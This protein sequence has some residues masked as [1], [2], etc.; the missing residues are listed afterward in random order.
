MSKALSCLFLWSVLPVLLW[1]QSA[2]CP[3]VEI[4]G[5]PQIT[6]PCSDSTECTTLTATYPDIRQTVDAP[7]AYLVN[8]I[9]YAGHEQ[10]QVPGATPILVNQDDVYSGVINLPFTFCFY[11][12]QYNQ[13]VVG[14]NGT[15]SFDVSYAGNASGYSMC[16]WW[17]TPYT[18]P[19]TQSP[20]PRNAIFACFHDIDPTVVGPADK[21]IEFALIGTAP[22]RRLVVN[23]RNIPQFSCISTSSTF[24]CVLYENTNVIEMYIQKKPVCS[25]WN[26]GVATIGVQNL[27]CNQAIAAPGRN[28]TV[29]TTT[30]ASSEAW[31]FIPNGPSLLNSVQLLDSSQAVIATGV[32][33]AAS[34]GVLTT[35]FNNIC[36]GGTSAQYYI[37]A[38]YT[39]CSGIALSNTDSVLLVRTLPPT[40]PAVVSP[41][42]YCQ[43]AAATALTAAGT[44]LLWYTAAAGG[45]GSAAAPTPSTTA[46]GNTT[47][48]VSQTANG[49]ESPRTPIVVEVNA[50]QHNTTTAQ[51][52]PGGTYPFGSQTITA[53]GTYAETFTAANGCDSVVTLTMTVGTTIQVNIDQA[54]CQGGNVTFNGTTY[55]ASGSYS[56]TTTSSGGCDSTTTL[57][58]TVSPQVTPAFAAIAPICSGAT[59]PVLP[60]TSTN[61]I[62]GT[63]S[64]ATVSNT[65]TGTYTFTP[66]AGQCA[67]ITTLTVTVNPT[68]NTTQTITV[69]ETQLPYP[70][71]G[72]SLT[73]AGTYTH[74]QAN[75]NGCDSTVT[76][77]FTVNPTIHTTQTVTV[78]ETQLPY[79][80]N[81]QSL[82]ASCTYTHTQP[83]AVG[84][85]SIVTLTFTVSPQ[86]TPAFAT[87]APICSGATAP[88]L[89]A[90]STNG[91]TG[92]WSPATVS[93][94]VTGT[95]TFT[96]N[97]GQCAT[98][99]TLTVTVNPTIN[100]TQTIT[101]CETQLPYPWN[102]QSLTAAGTY[103]HT[104]AN[105]NGCDSTVTLT[106]T[107]NPTI[108]T[109]QTVT[110]CETQ[111]PYPWNGQSLTASGT[112]TH[113]QPNAVGCDSIVTLTFTVSPQVTPAF[114]AIAPICSGATAPVLPAT[115]NNGI[116]GTWSPATVSNTATGTYT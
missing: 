114:A 6:F 77:T 96:P 99:A 87:I 69:C 89:P 94:T 13:V 86:V 65:V 1:G 73:A 22:C 15:I 78:C 92:T 8:S 80:W 82:T 61:G 10:F 112:Y 110:V 72:Q 52:C 27:A 14:A 55:S 46:P 53:A 11:G 104:Q 60:A 97:A 25:G 74:T 35:S 29:W 9:P 93:N 67:T 115:S 2:Q 3:D 44:G 107:V 111:L 100:T 85:D 113:T 40:A 28:A 66:N 19:T 101:V 26:C 64:P 33:S 4:S 38:N 84:C 37:R 54:I 20:F 68:I 90:T 81:G 108:H 21:G 91:I 57:N 62:T 98:T 43:G 106:F 75:V 95:Y 17:A 36:V 83:N 41:V 48:Y 24:Q 103:T 50:V 49:C 88:V 12:G 5:A 79:P 116:T 70:W 105:V 59:A 39:A 16:S 45:T 23:W 71:N 76:L 34:A 7:N 58:L 63:W 102:G 31:R 32:S 30:T 56:F 51:I 47:W 18:I 42:T 109:T